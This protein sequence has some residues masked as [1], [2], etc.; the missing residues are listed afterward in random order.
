MNIWTRNHHSPW[1]SL[2]AAALPEH[3]VYCL[4]SDHAPDG[5]RIDQRPQPS[6]VSVTTEWLA[7][8]DGVILL[9]APDDLNYWAQNAPMVYVAHNR[10]EFDGG[11][12]IAEFLARHDVPLV[13]ISEMKAQS[14]KD[15]GY[16]HPITVIGPGIDVTQFEPWTG[17][18][19]Y[20][21]TV[22][23]AL[24]RPLFDK[25][26][27]LEATRGLPVKLVGE[28]NEGIPGAVGPAK[29]WDELRR[30]YREAAVYLIPNKPPAEDAWNLSSLEAM[31]TGVPCMALTPGYPGINGV[32]HGGPSDVRNVME[33]S[34][35]GER[36]LSAGERA[37]Y[38]VAREFPMDR[39]AA[40]WRSVL[41]EVV[42]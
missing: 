38:W 15:A 28:G 14:W 2:L 7:R 37:R 8:G 1:V 19:G 10:C 21:L 39:F 16:E 17:D 30:H 4:P 35:K 5:W 33:R 27:W 41:S 31:A 36:W 9:H 24:D 12:R 40:S 25:A 23:N 3:T 6:N 11:P 26:A 20:V 22:C 32:L 34:T 18:G 29:D 13:A 42:K